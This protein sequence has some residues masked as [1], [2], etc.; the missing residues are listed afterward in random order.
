MKLFF[1]KLLITLKYRPQIISLLVVAVAFVIYSFNLTS[2]SNTTAFIYGDNMGLCSFINFLFTVLAL[3]SLLGA[4]PKR[5]KPKYVMIILAL[6]MILGVIG[7]NMLYVKGI[8]LALN[9]AVN[10]VVLNEKTQY[11]MKARKIVNVNSIILAVSFVLLATLPLYGKLLKRIKTNVEI[12]DNGDI[13]Q[14]DL[15]DD[16]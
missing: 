6:V 5:E 12:E 9:R 1:R 2:I 4:F 14:I 16:E 3:V 13:G 8:D 7:S 15:S 10:P 11:V